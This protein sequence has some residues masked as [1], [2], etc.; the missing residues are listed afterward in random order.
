[1]HIPDGFLD[2]RTAAAA[3]G[4]AGIGIALAL[5][6]V[7]RRLPRRRVPL[8]GLAAA[9]VF[10]AQM[11]NF[12]V[13][14]GTSGH[15]VGA[16]LSVVLLGLGAAVIVMTA[17]LMLQCFMFADGGITALGANA[18]NMAIIAPGIGYVVYS[19]LRRILGRG[20][21]STLLS[22][23]FAA[24]CATVAAAVACAAQLAASDTVAWRTVLLAMGGVH[25]LIG[26]GESIITMLV[27][28]VVAR[29]RPELLDISNE[30][31]VVHHPAVSLGVLA[32]LGVVVLVAPFASPLP[33]GLERVAERL[34]FA[35]RVT[36]LHAAPLPDY[37]VPQMHA[38]NP[39]LSTVVA[40]GIGTVVAFVLAWLVARALAPPAAGAVS[41]PDRR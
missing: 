23:G 37:T 4:L 7:R 19:T 35:G 28:A 13:A 1:M 17:V 34:G 39:W 10:A 40:G 20:L 18:L 15:L 32:M 30:G 21:R 27:V 26:L 36:V 25:M 24:W 29:S 41:R 12:P 6:D 5:Y 16:V 8:I 22:A 2:M 31:S 9:F 14:A 33:D 38:G 3:T 11:L